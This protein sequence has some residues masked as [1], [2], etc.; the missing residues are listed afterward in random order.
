[1][2]FLF[3]PNQELSIEGITYRLAEDPR[4]PGAAWVY[5]GR[6]STVYRLVSGD[7][8]RALKVFKTRF[9]HPYMAVLADWIAP[10][11]TVQGLLACRR[12]VLIPQF[13]MSLLRQ[14]LEL[15]YAIVMPWIEGSTWAR[16][17]QERTSLTDDQCLRIASA[18]AATLAEMEKRGLAHCELSGH[19]LIVPALTSSVDDQQ[20]TTVYIGSN[21][22]ENSAPVELVD[23]E[24]IYGP[25]LKMPDTLSA[26]YPVYVHRATQGDNWNSMADRFDGSLLLAEILGWCDERIRDVACSESYFDPNE[27]HQSSPRYLGL[28]AVLQEKWGNQAGILLEQTWNSSTPDQC[29]SFVEW[30]TAIA[31]FLPSQTQPQPG[32]PNLRESPIITSNKTAPAKTAIAT[33]QP[34]SKRTLK[35][36]RARK[37]PLQVPYGLEAQPATRPANESPRGLDEY[38]EQ[39]WIDA[40]RDYDAGG[41]TKDGAWEKDEYSSQYENEHEDR[42]EE[43]DQYTGEN[44]DRLGFRQEEYQQESEDADSMYSYSAQLDGD[45]VGAIAR[46][47][48]RSRRWVVTPVLLVIVGIVFAGYTL[49]QSDVTAKAKASASATAYMVSAMETGTAI[50]EAQA[51]ETTLALEATQ[52]AQTQIAQT[53]VAVLDI[54]AAIA[55]VTG[56]AIS[57]E[58]TETALA[59]EVAMQATETALAV[60][61]TE[62]AVAYAI[63][64]ALAAQA[65]ETALAEE[66]TATAVWLANTWFV[67]VYA[68]DGWQDTGLYLR[69]GDTVSITYYSGEWAVCCDTGSS[70]DIPPDHGEYNFFHE[71]GVP[72]G[73]LLEDTDLAGLIARVDYGEAVSV[74]HQIWIEVIASGWLQLRPNDPDAGLSDNAGSITVEVHINQ[75]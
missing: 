35:R 17:I 73:G 48:R 57:V 28:A 62:T 42:N 72:F 18:F 16:I 19:N 60:E 21:G 27:L 32:Q 47:E 68:A 23:L 65:T 13:H 8:V 52:T 69:A 55:Q 64:T 63:E 40:D 50:A 14:S 15:S 26:T 51:R 24:H 5:E 58:A 34:S 43:E 3:R 38:E 20:S 22:H 45:N 33:N 36:I 61:A 54:Q 49:Y 70:Y 2:A 10:Y 6:Q 25:G 31:T 39:D 59:V 46:S 4:I 11:A 53:A 44:E 12:M 74:G 56:T 30:L 7:G 66:A 71:G 29:P 1:M 67:K 41:Q 9:R 75:R 37:L